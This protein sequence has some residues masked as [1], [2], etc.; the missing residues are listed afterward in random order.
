M[1]WNLWVSVKFTQIT[2]AKVNFSSGVVQILGHFITN[3]GKI[4]TSKH[5]KNSCLFF[6]DFWAHKGA[7]PPPPLATAL[8]NDGPNLMIYS[9][10]LIVKCF[11]VSENHDRNLCDTFSCRRNSL[12]A[13]REATR[14]PIVS[15]INYRVN[16]TSVFTK[17][18]S[19]ARNYVFFV[20]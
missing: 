16:S 12:F 9:W 6:L 20:G 11:Q 7:R 2:G 15:S 4:N 18:C 5:I 19:K 3:R 13:D 17:V 1:A 14:K 8:T 10:R